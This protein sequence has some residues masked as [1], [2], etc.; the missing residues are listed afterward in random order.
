MCVSAPESKVTLAR[1]VGPLL[2]FIALVAGPH[3]QGQSPFRFREAY[4]LEQRMAP[5]RGGFTDISH[6]D[7]NMGRVKPTYRFGN[8]LIPNCQGPDGQSVSDLDNPR[9]YVGGTWIMLLQQVDTSRQQGAFE[10][11]LF[12]RCSSSWML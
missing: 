10:S 6:F 5:N 1:F 7:E 4:L 9:M 8:C 3:L 2:A 12:L 11:V